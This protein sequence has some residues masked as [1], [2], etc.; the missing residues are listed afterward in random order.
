MEFTTTVVI[1]LVVMIFIVLLAIARAS[2]EIIESKEATYIQKGALFTIAERSFYGVLEQAISNEYKIFG[3]VRV[4]DVL[5]PT[6]YLTKSDW[7]T[8]FNKISCKHFD[9]VLCNKDTLDVVAV[10]ELDDKSHSNKKTKNRDDFL[11][12]ACDG[13]G[14]KLIR[15]KARQSYQIESVRN[16]IIITLDNSEPEVNEENK[17][18]LST[19][20][21]KNKYGKPPEV[22]EKLTSSKLAKKHSMKTNNF[23]EEM[24]NKGYLSFEDDKHKLTSKGEDAN[25]EYISQSR[26]RGYFLWPEDFKLN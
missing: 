7:Q 6:S 22:I 4:A 9:Y 19:L 21:I 11:E 17:K 3:K 1:I 23:L 26:L 5:K 8:A 16:H 20:D 13:S 24:V 14:L 12:G 15:F 2:G 10:I 25:A 18:A